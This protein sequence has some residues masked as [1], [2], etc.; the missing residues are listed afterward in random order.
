MVRFLRY[1]T[2]RQLLL[3]AL[4]HEEFD[5]RAHY[6]QGTLGDVLAALITLYLPGRNLSQLR[7]EYPLSRA[8]VD[9]ELL[10]AAWRDTS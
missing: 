9:A 2:S 4:S 3:V 8:E 1:D 7:A 6:D 10:A 5:D